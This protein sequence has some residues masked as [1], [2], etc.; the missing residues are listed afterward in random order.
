MASDT[1]KIDCSMHGSQDTA[2]VCQHLAGCLEDG[3]PCGFY[4]PPE[5]D[6]PRPDAWCDACNDFL[7]R[8]DWEWTDEAEE[9]ASVK[10]L[11]GQCYDLIRNI[12]QI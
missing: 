2:F 10:L 7:E 4:Y 6:S 9:F 11:C 5:D 1:R 3:E 8:E 12:N